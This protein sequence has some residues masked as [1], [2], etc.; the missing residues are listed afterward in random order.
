MQITYTAPNRS[1]HYPYA[2][3]LHRADHLKAFI[4]GFSSLS[5][6]SSIPN[7]GKKLKR[8]DFFQNLYLASLKLNAP[9][10]VIDTF[11]KL[12]HKRLDNASYPWAKKSDAFIFYRTEGFY[13]TKRLHR[14]GST[15]LCI[16]EEVNSHIDVCES[17]MRNEFEQLG[18]GK[19]TEKF[20]DHSLR[21]QAYEEV[22][23]IL[24]PSE[25][26][27]SS[28]LSKGFS[29]EKLMKVNFGFPAIENSDYNF[30][31]RD[32]EIFRILYVGQLHYR[33]GL[34]Y[35]IEAF[36]RLK[37]PKKE[38]IIVGPKTSIT[39][40]EKTK[41][42]DNIIFTGS[43]KGESLKNQYRRA[44][45]FILPSVEEGLALVQGEALSYGVP[46]LITTNTGGDDLIKDGVEGFI[47]PV[48]NVDLLNNRLQIMADDSVLLE[49]MSF[50][51]FQAAQSLGSWDK[52]V[53]R[54][55]DQLSII[56]N[57]K[58]QHSN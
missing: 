50:A 23:H 46:L 4:S 53:E 26:V 22:D 24:C 25:F 43:L 10:F 6:R 49:R 31:N 37:H 41:I 27:K 57:T 38:F 17:L 20:Q 56:L 33:K 13:S 42:P 40:L 12:S 21:L 30:L 36:R 2:E 9:Y 32:K 11:N 45:V 55:I 28:F 7:I 16:M 54:L 48:G 51:A 19:Y 5:P 8:H 15:T 29:P 34:R 1:H 18:L 52:A 35:A 3:A 58:A 44:N 47:V 39:G 14:E